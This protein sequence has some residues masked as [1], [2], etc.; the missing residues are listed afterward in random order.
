MAIR[1]R[2]DFLAVVACADVDMSED[3]QAASAMF[4]PARGSHKP[5]MYLLDSSAADTWGQAAGALEAR[6]TADAALQDELNAHESHMLDVCGVSS[7]LVAQQTSWLGRCQFAIFLHMMAI[8]LRRVS[9][10][11][12]K[13]LALALAGLTQH[14]LP[15]GQLVL[16]LL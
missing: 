11:R 2:A 16:L 13:R 1:R 8:P 15:L 12:P 9:G 3:E 6:L 10:R 7:S 14:G 4:A 5:A